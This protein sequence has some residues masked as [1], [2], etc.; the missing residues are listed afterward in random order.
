MAVNLD[1]IVDEAVSDAF[2]SGGS[3]ATLELIA[4]FTNVFVTG[5]AVGFG[6][7]STLAVDVE[8]EIVLV[9]VLVLRFS[10][11]KVVFFPLVLFLL[12]LLLP[13]TRCSLIY[14]PNGSVIRKS[15]TRIIL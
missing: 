14:G 11:D 7:N 10:I 13:K 5:M 2:L 3:K 8:F 12:E 1:A 9:L 6:S 15:I 4:I